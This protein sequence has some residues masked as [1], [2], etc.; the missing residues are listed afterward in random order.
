MALVILRY[1]AAVFRSNVNI[2]THP[3]IAY[4]F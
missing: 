3:V 2:T 1:Y 4:D